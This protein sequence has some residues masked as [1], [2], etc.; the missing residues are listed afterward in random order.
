MQAASLEILYKNCQLF[1]Q[2]LKKMF[3]KKSE[4]LSTKAFLHQLRVQWFAGLD[5]DEHQQTLLVGILRKS[6]YVGVNPKIG[7]PQNGW[8]I[9]ENPIKM[10]DLGVPL[11]L[12]WH[13]CG[14]IVCIFQVGWNDL[15]SEWDWNVWIY[16]S[17]IPELKKMDLSYVTVISKE[18]AS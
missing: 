9:M 1:Y 12:G 14:S 2:N 13:P 17:K 6:P 3:N 11:F 18:P 10:H 16:L 15:W 4:F 8:F 5:L 7:V